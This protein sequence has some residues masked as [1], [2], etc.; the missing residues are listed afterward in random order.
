MSDE[1]NRLWLSLLLDSEEEARLTLMALTDYYRERRPSSGLAQTLLEDDWDQWLREGHVQLLLRYEGASSSVLPP[2]T[3]HVSYFL[4]P[5]LLPHVPAHGYWIKLV[6]VRSSS[7]A[8][9]TISLVES[10]RLG[11][12]THGN[13]AQQRGPL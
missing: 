13:L 6:A 12:F 11:D 3:L 5:R 2:S 9:W 4:G 7:A 1:E 10:R 8:R